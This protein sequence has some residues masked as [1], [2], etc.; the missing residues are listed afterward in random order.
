MAKAANHVPTGFHALTVHLFV[1]GAADYIDF[2]KRAF[3]A[4][5]IR[6][7]PGPN[8]K[9]MHVEMR[10]ADTHVLFADDFAEEFH[11]PPLAVGRLP[12]YLQL[13]VPDADAVFARAMAAGCT[14]VMP[15]ADMFWGDR[16]GQV[17][18]PFGIT[19]AIATRQE[20][21]T[22]QEIAERQQKMFASHG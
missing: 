18:D 11:L 22:P 8:G 16:F 14:T 17:T 21:L 6:R 13:Y 4:V 7:A 2:L 3:D 5:E 1:K 19:W 20:D 10:I 12:F 15:L 9:L